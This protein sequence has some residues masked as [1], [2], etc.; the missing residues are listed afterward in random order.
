MEIKEIGRTK[1]NKKDPVVYEERLKKA[2][3]EHEKMVKGKFEFTEAGAG[4]F[5]FN[6]RF[7]PGELITILKIVHGE[8][9]ELPLG[10]VK[11]LNNTVRKIRT[12]SPELPKRGVP[13]TFETQ[14]RVRFTNMD[15]L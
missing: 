5:E 14:S 15:Y 9:C 10:V 2:R 12:F 7:F 4:W 1:V 3:K 11:H 13:S 8:I 6:Y